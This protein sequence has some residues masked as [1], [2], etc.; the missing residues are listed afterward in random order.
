MLTLQVSEWQ[1]VDQFHGP[2]EI[3]TARH[4]ALGMCEGHCML[5]GIEAQSQ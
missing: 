1:E 4:L 2:E 5:N 3:L